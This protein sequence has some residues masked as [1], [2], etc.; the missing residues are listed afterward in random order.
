MTRA[1][2]CLLLI[3]SVCP[4][5]AGQEPGHPFE[6]KDGDRVALIGATFIEREQRYG[7]LELALQTRWPD[8]RILF[9][10]LGWSG[11]NVTG[12]SRL[13]FGTYRGTST[14]QEG[15]DHLFK[16]LDLF[17]PTVA[18]VGYGSNESFE[19]QAGL[20]KFVASY[21]QLLERLEATGAR[22]VLL[23]PIKHE[24]LGPPVPDPAE[25]NSNLELYT[26]AIRRL[27]EGKKYRFVDLFRGLETLKRPGVVVTDN[28]MHLTET[29]YFLATVA[30][31][32]GLGLTVS[33]TAKSAVAPG[34]Q[35]RISEG[36]QALRRLIVEKNRL[37]FH[38]YR[39]TNDTYL[40]GFRAYEQG[41][42]AGEI[43][44]FDPLV[45]EKDR[46]IHE[47]KQRLPGRTI[48]A[49]ARREVVR[50]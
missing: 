4:L 21:T 37:F 30:I 29:G 8:R 18:F 16:T 28:G 10:N 41:N 3:I 9:R 14:R 25:R 38:R 6:L 2:G 49:P 36:A 42:N 40:R 34:R 20:D 17:R 15:L 48:S 47:G 7:F 19:G 32:A 43:T 33:S 23:S 46:E 39:P 31:E 26:A 13:Y 50:P 1:L 22:I 45:E 11:D 27:A 12:E 35:V 44:Q 5:P 24:T